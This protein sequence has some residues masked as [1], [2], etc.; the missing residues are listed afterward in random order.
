MENKE[1]DLVGVPLSI[2]S[3]DSLDHIEHVTETVRVI[4]T[5]HS[6]LVAEIPQD[7][8]LDHAVV[9]KTAGTEAAGHHDVGGALIHRL[10]H[11]AQIEFKRQAGTLRGIARTQQQ[12]FFV[13]AGRHGYVH[14]EILEHLLEAQ[15][16]MTH[17][18]NGQVHV[19]G[20][21]LLYKLLGS[22]WLCILLKLS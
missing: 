17:M 4:C 20:F 5:T 6:E 14:A 9:T 10:D 16:E 19:M 2:Q 21:G 8:F 15:V 3:R 12:S 22:K 18:G 11:V 1:K 13:G 7:L